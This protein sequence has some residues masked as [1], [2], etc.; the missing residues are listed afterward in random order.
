MMGSGRSS[1]GRSSSVVS[2][3]DTGASRIRMVT[4]TPERVTHV[5]GLFCY[6][7]LRLVT[8]FCHWQVAFADVALLTKGL[9]VSFCGGATFAPR[10]D[11]IDMEH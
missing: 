8:V 4:E 11:V 2:L 7:S 10:V 9:K 1:L 5:S 3:I 6:L